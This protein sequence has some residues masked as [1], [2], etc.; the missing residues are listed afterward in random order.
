MTKLV[1]S[2]TSAETKSTLA[3]DREPWNVGDLEL[4]PIRILEE[5]RVVARPVLPILARAAVEHRHVAREQELP[6]E[7]VDISGGA[8]PERQVVHASCLPVKPMSTM[9]GYRPDDPDVRSPVAHPQHVG[10]GHHDPV[11][12]ILEE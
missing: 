5:H 1:N 4:D 12:E 2:I 3:L 7:R 6:V 9:L 8:Y 11:L 10:L